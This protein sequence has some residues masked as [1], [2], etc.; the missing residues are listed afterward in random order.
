MFKK[1]NVLTSS[2]ANNDEDQQVTHNETEMQIQIDTPLE[3][4]TDVPD[5][6]RESTHE[7]DVSSDDSQEDELEIQNET[8]ENNNQ[9]KKRS[10][11]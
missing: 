10:H 4:K 3:N 2:I 11:F 6:K 7:S 9:Q 1:E 8:I 5:K